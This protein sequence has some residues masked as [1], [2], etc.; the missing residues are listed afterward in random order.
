LNIS[1]SPVNK[2]IDTGQKRNRAETEKMI[3]NIWASI[4]EIDDFQNDDSFFELGGTSLSALDMVDELE[5]NI[6]GIKIPYEE[7]YTYPT[8]TKILDKFFTYNN[9][10]VNTVNPTALNPLLTPEQRQANYDRLI[11]Q[12]QGEEF[13]S[14]IPKNIFLTGGTGLVGMAVVD[15][16]IEHTTTGIFCIVRKGNYDSAAQRFWALYEQHYKVKN[17]DRITII[18]GDLALEGLGIHQKYEGLDN[19]DMIF[20]IAG[21][22]QFVSKNKTQDHINFIGTKNIIDWANKHGVKKLS[23]VSTVGI[24][25]RTMPTSIENFYETDTNIG[26]QAGG[27]IHSSSKLAAEEYIN[28]HYNYKSKIFR[29]SNIGGRYKDG[30]F[31]TDL[32]KNLMWLRLKSLS[33]LKFYCS[34][35]LNNTSGVGF[36]PVDVIATLITEISFAQID[37][38]HV[39]HMLRKTFFSIAEVLEAL[40]KVDIWP[41]CISHEDFV[42]YLS[43][44]DHKLNFHKVASKEANYAY[45]SDATN[46]VIS[47]LKL[48]NILYPDK[49]VYLD[50]LFESN[51]KV[52]IN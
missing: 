17:K 31:P 51:L 30:Y 38:L 5:K 50:R 7:I 28:N 37:S 22:P 44:Q 19:I 39:F 33:E 13:L 47:K 25:G 32:S 35:I 3:R 8:I 36:I 46:E 16:L 20:H 9:T 24:V 4:L 41:T 23:F 43:Q 18:Q 10:N 40:N 34:E 27:L 2:I 49:Q 48:N 26:Q 11:K 1:T 45:R 14:D 52:K 29:I 15:Y 12:I 6:T 21:S 42:E